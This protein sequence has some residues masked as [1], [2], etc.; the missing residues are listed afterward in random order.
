MANS[1][2]YRW[3]KVEFVCLGCGD[4]SRPHYA[5]EQCHQCYS[6]SKMKEIRAKKREEKAAAVAVTQPETTT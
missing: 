3:I 2:G 5:K 1:A 6:N 4:K